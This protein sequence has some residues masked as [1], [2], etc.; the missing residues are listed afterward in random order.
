MLCLYYNTKLRDHAQGNIKN[1]YSLFYR[2]VYSP[3]PTPARHI[4]M[5][6]IYIYNLLYT[7]QYSYVTSAFL[8]L[9]NTFLY[10]VACRHEASGN[11]GYLMF[12][13]LPQSADTAIL[14]CMHVKNSKSAVFGIHY[15]YGGYKFVWT[16][17]R[18]RRCTLFSCPSYIIFNQTIVNACKE[19]DWFIHDHAHC[20]A[21][22][23]HGEFKHAYTICHV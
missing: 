10:T 8:P 22:K 12:H 5:S 23:L 16:V 17:L 9:Q 21:H 18:A 20:I 6:A 13:L 15:W 2:T 1:S 11:H 4:Q 3:S 19:D 7:M 14:I